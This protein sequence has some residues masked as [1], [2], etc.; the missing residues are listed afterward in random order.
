MKKVLIGVAAFVAL[1]VFGSC[2]M[3]VG[4]MATDSDSKPSVTVT[5][6]TR[7]GKPMPSSTMEKM[8]KSQEQAVESAKN[9]LDFSS[10]SK[11]GLI[12]Q[13][14]FEKFSKE[15]ATFAVSQLKVDWKKQAVKSAEDYLDTGTFS[16]GS[17]IDQLKFDGF[18][19]EQAEFAADEV[20][21]TS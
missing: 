18:T 14:E 1:L 5:S 15:D 20:G 19:T 16:R 2:A 9:Y 6:P 12:R 21:F 11:K 10:F 17:L 13:L 3:V 8:T 4:S 7:T